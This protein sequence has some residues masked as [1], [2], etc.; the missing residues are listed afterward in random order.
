[1]K[2]FNTAMS[3]ICVSIEW[4]F[5]DTGEYFKFIDYKKNLKVGMSAVAKQYMVSA[6]FRNILTC[7]YGNATSEFFQNE[8][9]TPMEYLA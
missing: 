5:G 3:E 4:L 2:A 1:M 9:P 6:L 8:S 7:L